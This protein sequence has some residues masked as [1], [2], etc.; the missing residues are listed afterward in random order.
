MVLIGRLALSAACVLAIGAGSVG[1]SSAEIGRD[2]AAVD[3]YLQRGAAALVPGAATERNLAVINN[4]ADMTGEVELYYTTPLFVTIDEQKGLPPGCTIYYRNDDPHFPQVLKCAL[5]PLNSRQRHELSIPLKVLDGAPAVPTYG[6]AIVRAAKPDSD[7]ERTIVDNIARP[8]GTI[9]LPPA[10][11]QRS[12]ADEPRLAVLATPALVSSTPST[13]DYRI[14]NTGT[15]PAGN[16]RFIVVNPLYVNTS[17]AGAL[18]EG[19][20]MVLADP[21]PAIPEIVQCA[22]GT[23]DPG[24]SRNV[25]LPVKAVPNGPAG[26]VYG[27]AMVTDQ[28]GR[29]VPAAT[30]DVLGYP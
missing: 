29:S 20:S 26:E 15:G 30:S 12:A 3:L 14:V 16:V 6:T 8:G 1:A 10:A 2:G 18:P 27:A 24:Q 11:P 22:V 28:L 5:S 21:D 25:Q 13:S 9:A 17:T 23:V 4:G 19:C 7:Q